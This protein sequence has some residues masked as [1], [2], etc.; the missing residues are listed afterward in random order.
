MV[1]N[2]NK[3]HHIQ[4][5]VILDLVKKS[6]MRFT[7]LQSPRVPNNT[8]SYH[9]KKLLDGGY[10]EQGEDGYVATRK[11]LKLIVYQNPSKPSSTNPVTIIMLYVENANG[12][13]LLLNRNF[14]PFQGWYGLPSGLVHTGETLQE[15][16]CR[17]LK[18]KALIEP[19]KTIKLDEVGVLDFRYV[20]AETNDIFVHAIAFV[21]K[22]KILDDAE[23]LDDMGLKFG[24]LSWSTLSRKH[25]LPEVFAVK[26]MIKDKKGPFHSVTFKEPK[27]LPTFVDELTLED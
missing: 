24:Q 12:E 5:G 20:Q 19:K 7:E 10:I 17:E 8:F 14:K 9:L 13:V 15:A 16:A 27:Q 26:D 11:A 23:K 21:Y 1:D 2:G 6:P 4:R 22:Y 3:F 25:I 18:E